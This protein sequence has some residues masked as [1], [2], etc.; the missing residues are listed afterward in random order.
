[1]S[2]RQRRR[3]EKLRKEKEEAEGEEAEQDK[4]EDE[5]EETHQT[6]ISLNQFAGLI[7][8]EGKNPLNFDIG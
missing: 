2:L 6:K 1:M 8:S 3:L 7:D 4:E 5:Q